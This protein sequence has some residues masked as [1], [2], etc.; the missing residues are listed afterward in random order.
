MACAPDRLRQRC[1]LW[2]E[3]AVRQSAVF[4]EG[5]E[6]TRRIEVEVGTNDVHLT[7]EVRN[8]GFN[9]TLHMLCYNINVGFPALAKG[10]RY[11]API[12]GV[13]W[14]AHAQTCKGQ[15]VG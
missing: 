4:A 9:R 1:F 11:L 13:V 2:A 15:D 12:E 10:A 3:G 8:R 7:D 14:A 6:L 5:I